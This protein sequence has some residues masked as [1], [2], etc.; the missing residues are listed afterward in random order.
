MDPFRGLQGQ[1]YSLPRLS[2][3]Y[4]F[5]SVFGSA[6]ALQYKGIPCN[7]VFLE[8]SALGTISHSGELRDYLMVW[9]W[10]PIRHDGVAKYPSSEA[11]N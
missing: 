3:D 2:S 10:N 7:I 5:G 8:N 1:T 4:Y 11:K 6:V 9:P